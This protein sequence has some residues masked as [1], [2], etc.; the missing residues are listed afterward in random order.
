[1]WKPF[2]EETKSPTTELPQMHQADLTPLSVND[3]WGGGQTSQK[4]ANGV[5]LTYTA[6]QDTGS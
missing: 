1:M 2:Q 3:E 4:G 6:Y 5:L